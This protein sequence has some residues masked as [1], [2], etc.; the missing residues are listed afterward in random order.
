MTRNLS[1]A[2]GTADVG[3][4]ISRTLSQPDYLV[5]VSMESFEQD[6]SGVAVISARYQIS[7]ANGE[8]LSTQF[9]EQQAGR[10]SANSYDEMIV[11]L[12]QL[13]GGLCLEISQEI[14]RL[15]GAHAG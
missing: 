3:S 5:R 15:D 6:A 2:L 11:D 4:S 8:V 9:F 1:N 14:K 10:S 12:Q 7:G 13:F